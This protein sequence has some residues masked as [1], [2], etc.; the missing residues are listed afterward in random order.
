MEVV[1]EEGEEP[2]PILDNRDYNYTLTVQVSAWNA[3]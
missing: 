1:E 2:S 3:E